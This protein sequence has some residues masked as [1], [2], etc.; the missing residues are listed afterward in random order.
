MGVALLP[1][2]TMARIV[3]ILRPVGKE[4]VQALSIDDLREGGR[5]GGREG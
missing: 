2:L 5:E 4:G 3:G 1:E